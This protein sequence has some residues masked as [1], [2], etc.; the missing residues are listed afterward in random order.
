MVLQFFVCARGIF[1]R[2]SLYK[3][4]QSHLLRVIWLGMLR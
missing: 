4:L 2:E 3:T 1:N